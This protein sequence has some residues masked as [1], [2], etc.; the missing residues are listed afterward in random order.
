MAA[1]ENTDAKK[2][3]EM[4]KDNDVREFVEFVELLKSMD[5]GQKK[6]VRGYMDALRTMDEHMKKQ[7]A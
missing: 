6:Q 4:M 2:Y 3:E 7:P 1:V 5:Y